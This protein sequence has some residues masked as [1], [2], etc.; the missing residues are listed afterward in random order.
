MAKSRNL[1]V[2]QSGGP[3]PVINSRLRGVMETV[4][5]FD[6]VRTVYGARHGIEGVPKEELLDLSAQPAE[7]VGLL[8]YTP[9]AGSV[10]PRA[11]TSSRPVKRKTSSRAG[12]A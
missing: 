4:R 6:H 10:S 11:G 8:R 3:T 2:A 5:E 9:A 12:L 7:E 1:V